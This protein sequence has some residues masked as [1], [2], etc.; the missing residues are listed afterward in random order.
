MRKQH[1]RTGIGAAGPRVVVDLEPVDFQPVPEEEERE[2][3]EVL[4]LVAFPLARATFETGLD[5]HPL[6]LR[7][8]R[9]Y[10]VRV[11]LVNEKGERRPLVTKTIHIPGSPQEILAGFVG[12]RLKDGKPVL[13]LGFDKGSPL[14]RAVA[15]QL[16]DKERGAILR[17]LPDIPPLAPSE[18]RALKNGE[19]AQTETAEAGAEVREAHRNTLG[20][21]GEAIP[22]TIEET[23]AG[24]ET[25]KSEG[26]EPEWTPR[27]D[28]EKEMR[29]QQNSAPEENR[30][31]TRYTLSLAL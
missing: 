2:R 9:F 12:L 25:L 23:A 20:V 6:R 13:Y 17:I 19:E 22:G 11:Y 7:G 27:S 29:T 1:R 21:S 5:E 16:S 3:R 4:D 14:A 24:E 28:P 15:V 26:T 18:A 8:G 31:A 30:P 10:R